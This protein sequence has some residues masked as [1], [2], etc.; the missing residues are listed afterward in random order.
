PAA[1][2]ARGLVHRTARLLGRTPGG[3]D[4]RLTGLV[5][6][7]PGFGARLARWLA[8]AP[9]EWSAVVGPGVRRAMEERA[10]TP[11]PA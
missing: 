8:E 11:V 1:E 9:E 3:G 4:H 5:R 7:L 10:G 6:E 2:E